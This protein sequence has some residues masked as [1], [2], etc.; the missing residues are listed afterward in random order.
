MDPQIP[1]MPRGI[2][3]RIWD[4]LT[5]WPRRRHGVSLFLLLAMTVAIF[6]GVQYV[7][8]RDDPKRFAWFLGLYFIFFL[9]VIGRAVLEMFDI[10]REHIREREAV[11]KSTFCEGDFTEELGRRVSKGEAGS[12][13][14]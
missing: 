11:F 1:P 10:V 12:W 9:I 13:P 14:E 2:G 4:R 5:V 7:E 3:A 6:L 8:V